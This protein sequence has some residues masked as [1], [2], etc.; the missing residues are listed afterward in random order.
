M[1]FLLSTVCRRKASVHFI[2]VILSG[3]SVNFTL[4]I[5]SGASVN[6]LFFCDITCFRS[7][8]RVDGIFHFPHGNITSC[9][10]P[11]K[12]MSFFLT[13]GGKV[14]FPPFPHPRARKVTF[15]PAVKKKAH[16]KFVILW[17]NWPI[18]IF[19]SKSIWPD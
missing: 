10:N 15:P 8:Q 18:F 3:A 6:F 9:Q 19:L 13:A 12:W 17:K 1:I 5:L 11:L 4:V 2:L 14:T 7:V 16:S